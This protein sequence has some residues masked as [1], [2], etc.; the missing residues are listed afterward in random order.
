MRA[1]QRSLAGDAAVLEGR[2]T[3]THV[4][5]DA[6]LKIYLTAPVAVRAARRARDLGLPV[7]EVERTIVQRDQR[8]AAQMPPA[9]DAH[10]IDTGELDAD[11][12]TARILELV[13]EA[14]A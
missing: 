5:P 6:A 11:H 2:D 1:L 14:A 4:R 7:D 8:D 13:R 3:G 10:V 12:V 9:D